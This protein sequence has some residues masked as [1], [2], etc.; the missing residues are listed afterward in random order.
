MSPR[1]RLLLLFSISL[2]LFACGVWIPVLR[3]VGLFLNLLICVVAAADWLVSVRLNRLHIERH[4]SDVLSVGA[5]NPVSLEVRNTLDSSIELELNDETPRPGIAREIPAKMTIPG[6]VSR[7]LKYHFQ[8]HR[9]GR[10]DFPAVHIRAS[11]PLGLWTVQQ[12]RIL[13]S[14]VRILPD[15]RAVTKFELLARQN[16]MDELGIKMRRLRGQ[17]SEFERLRDYRREDELRM[18]DWKA[19]ARQRKLIAREF[20]VERNQ[21]ILVAVDCGRS[22]LNESDEISYLD[23]ALNASIML[24]YIALSQSDNV[25]L[26]AFSSKIERTVKPVRG[27]PAIQTVLQQSFD[28]EANRNTSDYNLAMEHLGRQFRKRSLVVFITHVI[29][30]QHLDSMCK[31]MLG[32][33]SPHLF[34]CVFLRDMGLTDVATRIPKQNIDAYQS[35][36]AAELLTAI[37]RK[38]AILKERGILALTSLPEKLS[39]DVINSYLD[40]KM[41]HLI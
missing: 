20:N 5:M 7:E 12:R 6:G 24:T 32:I 17:G 25:G 28:L 11:S 34:L 14:P 38:I 15:I 26:L 23:R 4:V 33:R 39:A 30:E 37:D 29:D 8:P 10:Y 35:A 41:R 18:V 13:V 31:A 19:T 21:N 27:K 9:R 22:M 2:P 3:I 16:R 1:I 40:V 36:A